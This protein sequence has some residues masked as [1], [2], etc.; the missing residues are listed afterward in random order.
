MNDVTQPG[1]DWSDID[2]VLLDMDGTLLDLGFDNFFWRQYVPRRFS[3]AKG[4]EIQH[5]LEKLEAL[6][7]EKQ[8]SLE[9]YCLD[10]WARELG[11]DIKAL[12]REVRDRVRFL[13]RVPEFLGSVR[14][15][16]K[17][18]ALVT[19]AHPESLLVKLEQ[20]ALHLHLDAV[21]SSHAFGYPKEDVR[22]W[23]KLQAHEPFDP[24]RTLLA[25]DSLPVLRA[26]SQYG[27][28]HL[29]A[30]RRPD[31]GEPPREVGEFP[32]V[33]DLHL[34]YTRKP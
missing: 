34:L 10:F 23:T 25:D 6:Y 11:L 21:Y 4:L 14:R 31:L 2:T 32:A 33:D 20:T 7:A 15:L 22:F 5:A 29:V 9:W 30:V 3:E 26:A 16:G 12:K 8:G 24:A 28:G 18:I 19:N 1:F 17:R 27:I 13:P